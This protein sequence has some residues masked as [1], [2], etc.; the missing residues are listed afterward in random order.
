MPKYE[1]M[2]IVASTISDDQIPTVTDGVLK[3]IADNDGTSVKEELMGKKKLA[4]PVKKTRNGFYAGVT[5]E[6]PGSKV[7]DLDTKVRTAPGIIRHL[8]INID[9]DIARMAKDVVAQ[10]V[11]NKNRN[12]RAKTVAPAEGAPAAEPVT[13]ENLDQKIEDALTEDL[14]NV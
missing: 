7:S 9:E 8:I 1:L 13:D 12:E 4:Y 11:M 2:Y 5:F 3:F 10:E 14:K 6:M